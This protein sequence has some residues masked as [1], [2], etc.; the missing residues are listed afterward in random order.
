MQAIARRRREK[1]ELPLS[2]APTGKANKRRANQKQQQQQNP[3]AAAPANGRAVQRQAARTGPVDEEAATAAAAMLRASRIARSGADLAAP[4]SMM[5]PGSRAIVRRM[6]R[7]RAETFE[8]EEAEAGYPVPLGAGALHGGTRQRVSVLPRVAGEGEAMTSR[9][10]AVARAAAAAAE[11][12]RLA[13]SAGRAGASR[14]QRRE[15][16]RLAVRLVTR[17][18]CAWM[19]STRMGVGAERGAGALSV[20]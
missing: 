11:R 19:S 10:K 8:R 13:K 3:T 2:A 7:R 14:H 6:H 15:A 4:R 1:R 12:N 16:D 9:V 17:E 5:S 20:L 18:L